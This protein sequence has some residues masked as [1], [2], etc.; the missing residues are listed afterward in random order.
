MML[1]MVTI[2][3]KQKVVEHAG[4]IDDPEFMLVVTVHSA[5]REAGGISGQINRQGK[6]GRQVQHCNPDRSHQPNLDERLRARSEMPR[7]AGMMRQMSFAPDRLGDAEQQAEVRREK[8][9]QPAAAEETIVNE[10][11]RN[12]V[13]VP[14]N[15]ES[16]D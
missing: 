4:V 11:V 10:V 6:N 7:P 9:I 5:Q 13:R 1:G 3:E 2:V 16:P 8:R 12:R 14:P 15:P